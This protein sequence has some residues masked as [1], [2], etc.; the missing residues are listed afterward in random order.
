LFQGFIN[1][2]LTRPLVVFDLETTGTNPERDRIVEIAL[3]VFYPDGLVVPWE[4]IFDPGVPIPASASAVHGITDAHVAG[5][6]PFANVAPDLWRL[7]DHADWAGFNIARF[8]VP[9]LVAEFARAGW[10]LDVRGRAILDALEVFHRR[11]PR[12]LG[13]ALRFYCGREHHHQ[14]RAGADVAAAA[15]V[16]DAQLA[17]YTDL[18]RRPAELHVWMHPLDVAGRF[19]L[20]DGHAVFSF[21]KHAGRRLAE[22]AMQDPDYLV[23]ML[24]QGF[25]EDAKDLVRH[26][27]PDTGTWSPGS[28]R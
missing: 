25:L 19:R 22:V 14:H 28:P 17:R 21:G 23:W 6:P 5:R 20:E 12:D 1:L 18:P 9:L 16:L 27:L 24:R 7:F 15:A 26:V 11:E 4:T 2:C 13:A 3:L 8:D 10:F